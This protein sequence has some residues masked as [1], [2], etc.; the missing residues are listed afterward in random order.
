[1][2]KI[3]I[4]GEGWFGGKGK[5]LLLKGGAIYYSIYLCL[6]DSIQLIYSIDFRQFN[7]TK[8][9][10]LAINNNQTLAVRVPFQSTSFFSA[11]RPVSQKQD[12][13]INVCMLICFYLSTL[14][15]GQQ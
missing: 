5:C 11:Q 3:T 9:I 4:L 1:M 10:M 13:Y 14:L 8:T 15:D 7:C 6:Y 2:F 12:Q